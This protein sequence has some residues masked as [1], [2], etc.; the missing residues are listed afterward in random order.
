ME[1][2]TCK[3]CVF[4]YDDESEERG[5]CHRYPPK[6]AQTKEQQKESEL[7]GCGIFES[8]F[9][10][11]HNSEWCGEHPEFPAYLAS[12]RDNA[13]VEQSRTVTSK[14]SRVDVPGERA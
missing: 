7:A 1:R 11:V 6:V 14:E 13:D 9:P 8:W 3:T 4:F 5:E 12:E 10:D 2:P